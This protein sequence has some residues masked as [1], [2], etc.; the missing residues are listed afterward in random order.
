M[1]KKLGKALLGAVV[2][3]GLFGCTQ[4]ASEG[5]EVTAVEPVKIL[6]PTGAPALAVLGAVGDE[7]ITIDY[8]EGTDLLTAE[9]AKADSEY[10]IIVAPTNL[11]AKIYSNTQAFNLEATL[12]WGNLYLVGPADTD[13][14]AVEVAAF[15]EQAVPGLVFRKVF[16][17]LTPTYYGSVQ[18]AQQALLTGNADVSLLAQPVAAATIAKAQEMGKEFTVLADLQALYQQNTGSDLKGYPQ[19][20]LF[21]KAGNQDKVQ[22]AL[23]EI[24]SF[25][26]EFNEEAAKEKI[27]L[28]TVEAIGVPNAEIAIKTWEKQNILYI[29]G[30]NAKDAIVEFLS[31]FGMEYPEGLIIE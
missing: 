4:K 19:A 31:T 12:T 1:F 13:I 24:C 29:A 6:C 10:D 22:H 9:L 2:A 7:N 17:D 21:V 18:E 23:T 20:S 15:G 11:G 25:D 28:A 8:T 14:T 30:T 16:A 26:A 3:F 27:E 5:V